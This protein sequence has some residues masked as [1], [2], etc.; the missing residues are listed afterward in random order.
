VDI[1]LTSEEHQSDRCATTQSRDF[2]VEDIASRLRKFAVVGHASDGA[3]T[4][5]SKFS[6]EEHVSLVS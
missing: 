6:L 1:S 3:K 2:E 4:K 5:T